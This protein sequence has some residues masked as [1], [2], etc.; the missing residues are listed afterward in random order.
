MR[1][2]GAARLPRLTKR[3]N[4]DTAGN[5]FGGCDVPLVVRVMSD[6]GNRIAALLAQVTIWTLPAFVPQATEA[7]RAYVANC[8]VTAGSSIVTDCPLLH[9]PEGDQPDTPSTLNRTKIRS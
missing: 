3:G 6:P 9:S 1:P 2:Y 8:F 5:T 7:H 4:P